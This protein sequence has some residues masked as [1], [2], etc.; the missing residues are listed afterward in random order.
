MGKKNIENIEFDY[1]SKTPSY[2]RIIMDMF[3]ESVVTPQKK[4]YMRSFYNSILNNSNANEIGEI[5]TTS[6][7]FIE[8]LRSTNLDEVYKFVED[9]YELYIEKMMSDIA[10]RGIIFDRLHDCICDFVGNLSLN[11]EIEN[12][13]VHFGK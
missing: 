10:N 9:V 3:P 13:R 1:Y 7:M 11:S 12:I 5:I 8:K 4:M 6:S 2:V